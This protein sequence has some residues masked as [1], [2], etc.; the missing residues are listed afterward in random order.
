MRPHT[1]T[2][3]CTSVPTPS[4]LHLVYI[5]RSAKVKQHTTLYVRM[6]VCTNNSPAPL[7]CHSCADVA[8]GGGNDRRDTRTMNKN[9][10]QHTKSLSRGGQ[11][12]Y[13]GHG[14]LMSR[15]TITESQDHRA[16]EINEYGIWA[17]C[18]INEM[19][20]G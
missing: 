20:V 8:V 3:C 16:V 17:R 7:M 12:K 10:R 13:G 14:E 19:S 15:I 1:G 2:E 4:C 18:M 11:T 9:E 6:F 5:V